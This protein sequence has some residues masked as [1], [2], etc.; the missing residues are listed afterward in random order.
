MELRCEKNTGFMFSPKIV[1]E[2]NETLT[3]YDGISFGTTY[4]VYGIILY[5]E[6]IYYLIYDDF[7][8]PNWYYAE[9]FSVISNSLPEKWYIKHFGQSESL[10]AIWGYYEL[11]NVDN[12]FDGL[13]EQEQQAIDLFFK[14][15]KEIDN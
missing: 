10:T 9:L 11:V 14:R 13:G 12:H 5:E 4:S 1:R 15:K 6:G 3:S 8:M 7:K 2:G